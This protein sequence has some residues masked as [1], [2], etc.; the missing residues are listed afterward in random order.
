MWARARC[1]IERLQRGQPRPRIFMIP[2]R[3]RRP[4]QC[5]PSD[6]R[7]PCSTCARDR[8]LGRAHARHQTAW[9]GSYDNTSRQTSSRWRSG[10]GSVAMGPNGL[11]RCH[12]Q[13]LLRRA[14]GR[15]EGAG[16]C[17]IIISHQGSHAGTRARSER[18]GEWSRAAPQS[19]GVASRPD[20]T[21]LDRCEADSNAV[22]CWR[23]V[24]VT[25]GTFMHAGHIRGRRGGRA[26]L[27]CVGDAIRQLGPVK[28][29]SDLTCFGYFIL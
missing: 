19:A 9:A 29:V 12:R 27:K 17:G 15:R 14:R 11:S 4:P 16:R 13:H 8:V 18:V 2:R 23:H 22:W 24:G 7:R 21:V 6:T 28:S 1:A 5:V 3:L 25:I 26:R 10:R 20:R